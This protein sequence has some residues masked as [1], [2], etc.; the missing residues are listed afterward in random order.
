MKQLIITPKL[1]IN[2]HICELACS[3]VHSHNFQTVN[4]RVKTIKFEQDE[5]SVPEICLQC[6]DAACIKA[7]PSKAIYLEESLNTVLINYNRCVGCMSCVAGCPFGN[8][9]YDPEKLGQVYKCDH[10]LGDPA[11]AKFCPTGAIQYTERGPLAGKQQMLF[12]NGFSDKV[13]ATR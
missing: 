9:L 10:C 4:S 3:L 2:C 8:M 5:I 13:G 6:V 1:C 12:Q 11:C 7:C